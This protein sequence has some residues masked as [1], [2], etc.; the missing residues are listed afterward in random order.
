MSAIALVPALVFA[1]LAW[2]AERRRRVLEDE[3]AALDVA[4]ARL[5]ALRGATEALAEATD[6]AQRRHAR[7][8]GG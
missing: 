2:T 1:L 8:T 5:Q 7:L 3:I 6:S 4:T